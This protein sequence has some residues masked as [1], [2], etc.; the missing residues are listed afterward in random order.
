VII[1]SSNYD[2]KQSYH[3]RP[4]EFTRWVESNA[5]GW[6]RLKKINNVYPSDPSDP[7][8][9]SQSDFYISEKVCS[10]MNKLLT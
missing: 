7:D 4:R 5:S 10:E 9:T 2:G 8:N 1:Y 3:E 6:K